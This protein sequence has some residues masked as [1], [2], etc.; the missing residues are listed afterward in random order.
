MKATGRRL[1]TAPTSDCRRRC[2][3]GTVTARM[4]SAVAT[5]ITGES[6]ACEYPLPRG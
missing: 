1:S 4:T 2:S 6:R 5:A 3:G